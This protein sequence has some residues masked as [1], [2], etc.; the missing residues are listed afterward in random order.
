MYILVIGRL[1]HDNNQYATEIATLQT[2]FWD[3]DL[4]EIIEGT[5]GEAEWKL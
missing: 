1:I 4:S 3:K 5:W 2:W